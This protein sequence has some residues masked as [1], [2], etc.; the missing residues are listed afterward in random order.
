[1]TI[2]INWKEDIVTGH[3]QSPTGKRMEAPLAQQSTFSVL[4]NPIG[5]VASPTALS[6]S[7]DS[8]L[9]RSGSGSVASITAAVQTVLARAAG[10]LTAIAM[11]ANTVLGRQASGDLGPVKV[12]PDMMAP[13]FREYTATLASSPSGTTVTIAAGET[14]GTWAAV[15]SNRQVVPE[16]GLYEIEFFAEGTTAATTLFGWWL[17]LGINGTTSSIRLALAYKEATG[18]AGNAPLTGKCRYRITNPATQAISAITAS[19]G[20]NTSINSS[21][22]M[23]IRKIAP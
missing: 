21:G 10:S 1:M 22:R 13:L 3:L 23:T 12:T 17:D 14:V 4:A 11:T 8:V 6:V 5:S 15:A 16:A 7:A 9:G 2:S 18:A 20:A 19:G